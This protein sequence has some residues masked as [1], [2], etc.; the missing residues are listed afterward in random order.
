M[1]QRMEFSGDIQL[2]VRLIS[3][4]VL[5]LTVSKLF[6][7]I[8][9]FVQ[10]PETNRINS[11]HALWAFFI[12]VMI[13]TFW[14]EEAQTFARVEWSFWLY[15]YQIIYCSSFL[16]IA[17]I[18][19]PDEAKG[20]ENH[21]DYLIARRGWF[22]GVLIFNYAL[23]L[24]DGLI[25]EGWDESFFHPLFIVINLVMVTMLAIGMVSKRHGVHLAI[26]VIMVV[27]SLLMMA[28]E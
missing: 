10:H 9:K 19:L 22:Y 18:L 16:F 3:G 21:Y 13:L 28:V 2:Y 6:T 24:G 25:K 12:F 26:A 11:L 8:A 27:L 14:W 7:G 23:G 1:G 20:F 5:G 4:M 17:S 15:T